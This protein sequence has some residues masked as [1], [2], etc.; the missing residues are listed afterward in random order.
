MP[1]APSTDRTSYGPRRV[2]A[3]RAI[4][5][6][7]ILVA[8]PLAAKEKEPTRPTPPGRRRAEASDGSLVYAERRGQSGAAGKGRR[9]KTASFILRF[10]KGISHRVL[11]PLNRF[12]AY[13]T[14]SAVSPG[15]TLT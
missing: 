14:P 6:R 8:Q 7:L 5:A 12:N 15:E 10:G 4:T 1:P 13:Q 3:D 11:D 2:P 9:K